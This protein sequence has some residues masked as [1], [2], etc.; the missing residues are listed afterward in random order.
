LPFAL[1]IP[2]IYNIF[3]EKFI[4]KHENYILNEPSSNAKMVY[5]HFIKISARFIKC[6]NKDY[7]Q[8]LKSYEN[9]NNK[10]KIDLLL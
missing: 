5:F 9:F 8:I 6:L 1:D 10:E 7:K 3:N 2:P 4:K